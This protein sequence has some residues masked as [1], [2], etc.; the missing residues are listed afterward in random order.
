MALP[1]FRNSL[2]GDLAFTLLLFGAL[3][4]AEA[5]FPALRASD[6]RAGG[7]RARPAPV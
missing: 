7:P 4:L 1:F 3:A 2:A 6:T 5:R